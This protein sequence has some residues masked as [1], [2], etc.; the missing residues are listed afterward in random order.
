M[1]LLNLI[2]QKTAEH[3][4]FCVHSLHPSLLFPGHSLL[5]VLN[6]LFLELCP[7]NIPFPISDGCLA[8]VDIVQ[9]LLVFHELIIVLFVDRVFLGLN[10]APEFQFFVIVFLLAFPVL[11]LFEPSLLPKC[12]FLEHSPFL[13]LYSHFL[14][15][16]FI[17]HSFSI[18]LMHEFLLLNGPT[19]L[20]LSSPT[21]FLLHLAIL[22]CK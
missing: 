10:P 15:K 14:P 19:T 3:V 12:E 21:L 4:F 6:L 1:L 17:F 13:L 11:L 22:R 7:L 5:E 16:V 9:S 18:V 20:F 8:F 2:L